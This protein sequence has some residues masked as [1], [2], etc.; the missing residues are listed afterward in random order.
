[1]PTRDATESID[2]A[3]SL[4]D[5]AHSVCLRYRLPQETVRLQLEPCMIRMRRVDLDMIFRNLIDNA[6][7]YAGT[8]PHVEVRQVFVAP[9]RCR[10]WVSDNG[11]GIP[12]Q[13]RRKIFGRFVRLGSEL[14]RKTPGTGLGLYIVRTLVKRH[15]GRIAVLD[16][17]DA[18]GTVFEVE[19]PS[20]YKA[21]TNSSAQV[22]EPPDTTVPKNPT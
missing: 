2:L 19:L 10:V 14:E 1:V 22:L 5:C 20:A 17:R 11:T 3:R 12:R 7:K 4:A 15:K 13:L 21:V 6:V 8:P 9:N 18:Q 16:R